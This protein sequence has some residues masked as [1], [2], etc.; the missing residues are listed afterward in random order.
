MGFERKG[1]EVG[2][3]NVAV[4]CRVLRIH[5]KLCAFRLGSESDDG[6]AHIRWKPRNLEITS[7]LSQRSHR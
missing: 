3:E 4:K 5:C 2:R 7:S 1:N 6:I